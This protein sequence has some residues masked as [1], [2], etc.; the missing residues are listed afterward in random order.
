MYSLPERRRACR[1]LEDS[2]RAIGRIPVTFGSRVPPCPARSMFSRRFVQAVTSW[3][4]GPAGLS[5]FII[6]KRM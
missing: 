3:L 4:D 1:V 2:W 5:R 6:P